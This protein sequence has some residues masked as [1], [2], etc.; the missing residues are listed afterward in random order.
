MKAN[1]RKDSYVNGNQTE[2]NATSIV[3]SM[4]SDTIVLTI[5]KT[6]AEFVERLDG[7][8]PDVTVTRLKTGAF[9]AAGDD[10]EAL[11]QYVDD[12]TGGGKKEL[13]QIWRTSNVAKEKTRSKNLLQK[14]QKEDRA[15]QGRQLL[16]P[17]CL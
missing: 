9:R 2:R 12:I 16:S 6:Y 5:P 7:L 3:D 14:N 15:V 13:D 10:Q 11:I 4:T 1:T 8:H 17:D